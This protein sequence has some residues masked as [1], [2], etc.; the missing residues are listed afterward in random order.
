[1]RHLLLAIL[2]GW[3]SG[4]HTRQL[5]KCSCFSWYGHSP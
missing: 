2:Y 4:M 1:M 5:N 3:L